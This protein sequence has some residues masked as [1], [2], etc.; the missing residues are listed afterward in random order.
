MAQVMPKWHGKKY[1]P[2]PAIP[3]IPNSDHSV[4]FDNKK[5]LTKKK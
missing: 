1:A 3:T 2:N 4:A 5:F